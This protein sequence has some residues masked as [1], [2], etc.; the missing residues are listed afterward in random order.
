MSP[1]LEQLL[2]ALGGLMGPDGLSRVFF[3]LFPL[4][5][6][7]ELPLM[8]MVMLG[9]LRWFAR[10]RTRVPKISVYRPKVSCIITCYS[11][12]MDVQTTLLSPVSYT[13]LT[14][15]TIYSV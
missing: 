11:E 12:G 5:L 2:S 13:H 3:M 4:F 15:P 7:F 1:F 8:I 10:R 9:V 14:L 6:I